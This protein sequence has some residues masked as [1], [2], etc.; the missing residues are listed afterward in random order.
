MDRHRLAAALITAATMLAAGR[1]VAGDGASNHARG[2]HAAARLFEDAGAAEDRGDHAAAARLYAEADALSPNAVALQAALNAAIAADD[3]GIGMELA[4]R[5]ASRDGE[6]ALATL[7]SE[8]RDRFRPR[9]GRMI[10]TCKGCSARLDKAAVDLDHPRW[11]SAG[12]HLVEFDVGGNHT[13]H[14]VRVDPGRIV[15]ATPD[16]VAAPAPA[17][18]PAPA[19]ASVSDSASVSGPVTGPVTAAAPA[20]A[21]ADTADRGGVSQAWFWTGVGL[22]ALSAGMT[23][24]S[25][26]DTI[27]KHDQYT[28]NPT[29]AA[30]KAGMAAD[31]RTQVLCVVTAALGLGT[32]ALGVFAVQ[33][34][35]PAA[36][37]TGAVAPTP[38]GAAASLRAAF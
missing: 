13:R 37:V 5:A 28:Q 27:D 8:A 24:A 15:R 33:W 32:T 25:G 12:F 35:T 17:P 14:L 18:A 1:A 29:E 4:E 22:T 6:A 7:A 26:A 36:Q 16:S 9:A 34:K 19:S 20:L 30:A 11:V 23:I 3:A 38:G 21:A 2:P 31:A 10:I